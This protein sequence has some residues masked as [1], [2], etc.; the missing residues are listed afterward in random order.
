MNAPSQQPQA[1]AAAPLAVRRLAARLPT[2]PPHE[3]VFLYDGAGIPVETSAIEAV[4]L[5]RQGEE[6]ARRWLESGVTRVYLGEA[7]LIDGALVERLSANFGPER[8]GVYVPARRLEVGW[9]LDAESN[10]DFRVMRPT[11]CEPCWE[12]LM[13]DGTRTGTFAAWWIGE[14]FARGAASALVRADIAD[15]T[16]LGI[17]A[18][19]TAQWGDRLWIAPLEQDR[20]DLESWVTLAQATRLAI[21]DP[22]YDAHPYLAALRGAAPTGANN[23][24]AG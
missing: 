7:A 2:P 23:E 5:T 21:P 22:M 4:V 6:R 19:L 15:D 18:A 14:M 13:A 10:A 11:L 1:R 3:P 17:L 24:A 12:I 8:V 9:D 16:D 20:P